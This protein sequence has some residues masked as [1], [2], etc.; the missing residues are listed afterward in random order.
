MEVNENSELMPINSKHKTCRKSEE[1]EP[2]NNLSKY[3]AI[4]VHNI[5]LIYLRRDMMESLIDDKP[6]FHDKVVGSIVR[7][8]I[9]SIDQKPDVYRLVKVVGIYLHEFSQ[10]FSL[11][12]VSTYRC[13]ICTSNISLISDIHICYSGTI[14]A[15]QPYKIGDKTADIMLEVLHLDMKEVVSI[16]A[17]SNQ[18]FTEVSY[19]EN[20]LIS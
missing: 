19:I 9:S 16:D 10:H 4:D 17:I 15:T 3:A 20:G 11:P 5:N 18:E 12:S 14:K 7:I 1:R 2:Q 8:R 6:N 13:L